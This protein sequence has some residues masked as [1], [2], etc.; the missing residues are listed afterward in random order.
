M[1]FRLITFELL[2]IQVHDDLF[3]NKVKCCFPVFSFTLNSGGGGA[4]TGRC[5]T[6]ALTGGGGGMSTSVGLVVRETSIIIDHAETT[7]D[8]MTKQ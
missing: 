2:Y 6:T 3:L 8:Q 5:T 7:K 4:S 1:L